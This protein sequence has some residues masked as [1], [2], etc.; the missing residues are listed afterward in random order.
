MVHS[1]FK[2]DKYVIRKVPTSVQ[3][4]RRKVAPETAS[5]PTFPQNAERRDKRK[6]T[7]KLPG[8]IASTAKTIFIEIDIH[9]LP[10]WVICNMIISNQYTKPT[11]HLT[12]SVGYIDHRTKPLSVLSGVKTNF[13]SSRQ[14]SGKAKCT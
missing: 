1:S 3:H 10:V 6:E 2:M 12:N 14:Y 9:Q 11:T 13:S 5:L 4:S 8:Q 7:S